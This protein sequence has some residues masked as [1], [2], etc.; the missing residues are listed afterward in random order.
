[1]VNRRTLDRIHKR[2]RVQFASKDIKGIAVTSD[3]SPTGCQLHS[4]AAL[5]EGSRIRGRLLLPDGSSIAFEAEV[6]WSRRV[7]WALGQQMPNSVGVSFTSPPAEGY[8]Q[9]LRHADSAVVH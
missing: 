9:L 2:V 3:I 8:Y 6:R 1:M 5:A 4:S 7:E